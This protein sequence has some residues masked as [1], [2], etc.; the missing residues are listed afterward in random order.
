VITTSRYASMETRRL[1]KTIAKTSGEPY[2]ARGKK[3]IDALADAARRD[4]EA[5]VRI[6]EERKGKAALIAAMRVDET[7][8]W[9]WGKETL[10]PGPGSEGRK[11]RAEGNG[12]KAERA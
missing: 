8:K 2:V 1:A 10:L 4:G 9:S 6:V 3:T 12:K 11:P 5:E 7:G